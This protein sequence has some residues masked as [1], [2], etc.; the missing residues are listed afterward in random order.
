[1]TIEVR[2]LTKKFGDFAALDNVD[3]RVGDG[4]LLALLVGMG[5]IAG[6]RALGF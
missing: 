3:L 6:L 4:E 5:T 1:M 2:N